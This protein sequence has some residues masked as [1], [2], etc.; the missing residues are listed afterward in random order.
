MLSMKEKLKF[1]FL[2]KLIYKSLMKTSQLYDLKKQLEDLEA[3]LNIGVPIVIK[4]IDNTHVH[5]LEQK[6]KEL[7]EIQN[8]SQRVKLNVGGQKFETT[9]NT[10]MSVKETLFYNVIICKKL[11]ITKEIFIDRNPELFVHIMDFIR[12]KKFNIKKFQRNELIQLKEDAEYY[13]VHELEKVLNIIKSQETKFIKI[14]VSSFY[15]NVGQTNVEVLHDKDLT[16]GICTNSPGWMTL[17]LE[18]I[19]Y[20]EEMDIGG[21]TGASDW[22][23][24]TG[25]GAGAIISTSLDGHIYTDVGAVPSGFGNQILTTK[26][27][28]SKAKFIKIVGIS[29]LG[30]GY[31][32]IK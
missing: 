11:D 24:S 30:I 6:I 19:S 32:K 10:L 31:I 27:I 15:A 3:K 2:N 23:Y 21:F 1:Y 25:Y 17:E 22:N 29:W 16:T 9:L 12:T 5:E 7:K 18:D 8:L 28:R 26:L 13:E 14:Q 4:E 20:F